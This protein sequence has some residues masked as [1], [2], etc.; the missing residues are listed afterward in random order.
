LAAFTPT[1]TGLDFPSKERRH[2]KELAIGIV[3]VGIILLL[4][5]L[6]DW[7]EERSFLLWLVFYLLA[8]GLTIAPF[9]TPMPVT[10]RPRGSGH[11]VHSPAWL[12]S[13]GLTTMLNVAARCTSLTGI[14][15]GRRQSKQVAGARDT[16]SGS[17]AIGRAEAHSAHGYRLVDALI[18]P[19]SA[20]SLRGSPAHVSSRASARGTRGA[21]RSRTTGHPC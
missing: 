5:R 8:G 15:A 4:G 10:S 1:C 14:S 12:A 3:V 21:W 20:R 7:F 6:A 13:F 16:V 11:L 19:A 18:L 2:I 17:D 9:G